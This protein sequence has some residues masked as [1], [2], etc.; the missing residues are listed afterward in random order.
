[1]KKGLA[2]VPLI[3]SIRSLLTTRE[4]ID[5]SIRPMTWPSRRTVYEFF[6]STAMESAIIPRSNSIGDIAAF[7]FGSGWRVMTQF[8]VRWLRRP[9]GAPSG[10]WT[11]QIKPKK[12]FCNYTASKRC[13]RDKFSTFFK[14]FWKLKIEDFWIIEILISKLTTL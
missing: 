4:T 11:G 9:Q 12:T 5:S 14:E 1:M 3:L 2:S 7:N 8:I 10:V 6:V 13:N